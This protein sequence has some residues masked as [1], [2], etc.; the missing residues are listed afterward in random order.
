MTENEQERLRKALAEIEKIQDQMTRLAADLAKMEV[1]SQ[2]LVD[3]QKKVDDS[4]QDADNRG[5][6]DK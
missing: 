5:K 4:E 3:S 1:I 6:G 2:I